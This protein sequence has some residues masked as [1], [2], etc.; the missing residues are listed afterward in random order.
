LTFQTI[1]LQNHT[2]NLNVGATIPDTL[3]ELPSLQGLFFGA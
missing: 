1:L 2:E 3:S